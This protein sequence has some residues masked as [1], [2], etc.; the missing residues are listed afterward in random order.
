MAYVT[1][2]KL[3]GGCKCTPCKIALKAC[4]LWQTPR[5]VLALEETGPEY[6]SAGFF[7]VGKGRSLLRAQPKL[8]TLVLQ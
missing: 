5:R 2:G 6:A 3:M 7:R 8:V 4:A 1:H